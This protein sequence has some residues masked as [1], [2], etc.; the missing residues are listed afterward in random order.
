MTAGLQPF[1]R[2]LRTD[3]ESQEI[4]HRFCPACTNKMR[5]ITRDL[6]WNW[7]TPYVHQSPQCIGGPGRSNKFWPISPPK[8][9]PPF[10]RF[11]PIS[12][13][14]LQKHHLELNNEPW[15]RNSERS[16]IVIQLVIRWPRPGENIRWEWSKPHTTDAISAQSI[17]SL[18]IKVNFMIELIPRPPLKTSCWSCKHSWRGD[19]ACDISLLWSQQLSPLSRLLIGFF[20]ILP[21]S[22]HRC[23]AL[24]ARQ[25][26]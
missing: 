11:S 10:S 26:H 19:R 21:D 8:L 14:L 2:L 1:W 16:K 9:S 20:R 25:A 24:P 18:Q 12:E 17:I 15:T 3:S 22:D 6:L 7:D 13:I 5:A 23:S 4:S